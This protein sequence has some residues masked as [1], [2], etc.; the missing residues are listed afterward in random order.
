MGKAQR[1][2]KMR[3]HAECGG[4]YV[5]TAEGMKEHADLCARAR[6]AGLLLPEGAGMITT[7]PDDTRRIV[8]VSSFKVRPKRR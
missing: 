1:A 7:R 6:S 2:S 3:R 5:G 4:Y 8:P